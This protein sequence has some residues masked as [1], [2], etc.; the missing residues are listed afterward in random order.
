[1]QCHVGPLR[2]S[3]CIEPV[4]NCPFPIVQDEPYRSLDVLGDVLLD[5]ELAHGFLGYTDMGLALVGAGLS[6]G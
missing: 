1:M 4:S 5:R 2:S 6:A 3:N